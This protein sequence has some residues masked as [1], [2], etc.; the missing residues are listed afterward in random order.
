MAKIQTW[1][2][3]Y[4]SGIQVEW[5]TN[6]SIVQ[7]S[8]CPYTNEITKSEYTNC[9]FPVIRIQRHDIPKIEMQYIPHVFIVAGFDGRDQLGISST[10]N[11]V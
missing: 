5:E 4:T 1:K 9:R 2:D 3:S 6:S 11:W 7:D 10:L 8:K